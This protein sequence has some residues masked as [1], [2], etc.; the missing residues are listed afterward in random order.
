M[1]LPWESRVP[2][3]S[4]PRRKTQPDQRMT[5]RISKVWRMIHPRIQIALY[6]KNFGKSS[7]WCGGLS[8]LFC[9]AG[10]VRLSKCMCPWLYRDRETTD[11]V[12][13]W[14]IIVMELNRLW[15]FWLGIPVPPRSWDFHF[16]TR[17]EL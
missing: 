7:T 14:A 13:R 12:F 1:E 3:W 5:T 6:G 16:P 17:D 15:N 9:P 11:N 8:Y 2:F 10:S 4:R